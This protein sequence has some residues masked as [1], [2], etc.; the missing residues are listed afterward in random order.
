MRQMW[1]RSDAGDL[2]AMFL[3][4]FKAWTIVPYGKRSVWAS[5]SRAHYDGKVIV[6]NEPVDLPSG[7]EL[8]FRV[9]EPAAAVA[10]ACRASP[11]CTFRG[12][13]TAVTMFSK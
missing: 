7:R 6:P 12:A 4:R 5:H 8:L 3:P 9:Y 10:A 11:C 2:P 1:S 13:M